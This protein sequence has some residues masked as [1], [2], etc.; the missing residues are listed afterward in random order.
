MPLF[1]ET[2]LFTPS[3][4]IQSASHCEWLLYAQLPALQLILV[5]IDACGV[6]WTELDMVLFLSSKERQQVC[7]FSLAA[8]PSTLILSSEQKLSL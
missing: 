1:V 7:V 6:A 4:Q 8:G 5:S 3:T 2:E